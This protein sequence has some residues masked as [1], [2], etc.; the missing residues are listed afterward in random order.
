MPRF[1]QP[2]TIEINDDYV[3]VRYR[4]PEEFETLRTPEWA[5]KA[6]ESVADGS[7]LRVGKPAK[8]ENW[9]PQEVRFPEPVDTTDAR[10][11][12]DEILQRIEI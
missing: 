11:K 8:G 5:R 1:P 6:A 12:A 10:R 3:C 2:S 4:D 7:E 9:I